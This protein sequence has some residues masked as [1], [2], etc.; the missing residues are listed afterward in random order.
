MRGALDYESCRSSALSLSRLLCD[1]FRPARIICKARLDRPLRAMSSAIG[2]AFSR[3]RTPVTH[4][5]RCGS[6]YSVYASAGSGVAAR[7][8]MPRGHA[9]GMP[10]AVAPWRRCRK[11]AT[12]LDQHAFKNQVGTVTGSHFIFSAPCVRG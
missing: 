3:G 8:G 6:G 10:A 5:S 1:G 9:A 4:S 11:T 12:R 7:G 2:I